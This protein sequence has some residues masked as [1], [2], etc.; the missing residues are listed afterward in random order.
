[1]GAPT[2]WLAAPIFCE[3]RSGSA[4]GAKQLVRGD[5]VGFF[6]G[7]AEMR[8]VIKAAV[9]R[10]FADLPYAAFAQGFVAGGQAL[11]P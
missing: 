8:E 6:K 5:T 9:E 7:F 11:K 1:M 2:A 10:G 3:G 4:S